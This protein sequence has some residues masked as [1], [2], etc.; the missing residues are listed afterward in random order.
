MDWPRL[1]ATFGALAVMG[2]LIVALRWTWGTGKELRLPDPDDP[3][4]SGL[5]EEVA[6][7]PTE[8][9]AQALRSR[10]TAAGIRATVGREAGAFRLLVFTDDAG[11]AK[12]VLRD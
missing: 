5:L 4:G 12:L 11:P 6:R 9:A 10:L 2:I 8:A 1:F 7:V 3:A